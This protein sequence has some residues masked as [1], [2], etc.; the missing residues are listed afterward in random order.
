MTDRLAPQRREVAVGHKLLSWERAAAQQQ[1]PVAYRPLQVAD[2]RRLE[3]ADKPQPEAFADTTRREIPAQ[4]PAE[5]PE[6]G[7]GRD[8]TREPVAAAP[9]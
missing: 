4:R 6:Q 5:R 3:V 7:T 9:R 2:T 1:S 8:F